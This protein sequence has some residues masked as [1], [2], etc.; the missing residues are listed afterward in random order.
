MAKIDLLSE[1][2][3]AKKKTPNYIKTEVFDTDT[4]KILTENYSSILSGVGEDVSREGLLK[5]PLRAAKAMQFL[6]HGNQM[7]RR[8]SRN[9]EAPLRLRRAIRAGVALQGKVPAAR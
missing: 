1:L 8:R 2:I 6:T 5:T 9:R 3:M 4:T 7:D